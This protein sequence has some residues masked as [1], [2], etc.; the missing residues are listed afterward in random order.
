MAAFGFAEDLGEVQLDFAA[1]A[2]DGAGYGLVGLVLGEHDRADRADSRAGGAVG[3]ALV[4]LDDSERGFRIDAVDA[5]EAEVHAVH[6]VG[7]SVVIDDRIPARGELGVER[8]R[9]FLFSDGAAFLGRKRGLRRRVFALGRLDDGA[10]GA[11]EDVQRAGGEGGGGGVAQV[12]TMELAGVAIDFEILARED[13]LG[14]SGV[15][16][17]EADQVAVDRAEEGGTFVVFAQVVDGIDAMVGDV[18]LGQLGDEFVKFGL[19]LGG[20]VG[21]DAG[22]HHRGGAAGGEGGKVGEHGRVSIHQERSLRV[23]G[24]ELGVGGSRRT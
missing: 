12:Y 24:Y 3:A 17:S 21:R 11:F 6:A 13:P 23:M 1:L 15:V 14:G 5:E 8:R 16:P 19:E 10:G 18:E 9:E 20:F 2:A 7:A 22:E 4:L